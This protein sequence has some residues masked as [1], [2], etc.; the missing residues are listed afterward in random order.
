MAGNLVAEKKKFTIPPMAIVAG[1]GGLAGL[2]G[3]WYPGS[4]LEERSYGGG[5][6]NGGCQ[7][8]RQESQVRRSPTAQTQAE[9]VMESHES[10][11]KQSIVEICGNLLNAGDRPLNSVEITLGLLR[12][13]RGDARWPSLQ[14]D[15]LAGTT[16]P[17]HQEHRGLAPG[18]VKPFHVAFDDVPDSWNQAMPHR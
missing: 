17:D 18:Q 7:G 6:A 4:F 10:Y 12:S 8:L 15:H 1:C 14:R 9:P 2:A 3:F 11:L 13:R 16:V 5:S